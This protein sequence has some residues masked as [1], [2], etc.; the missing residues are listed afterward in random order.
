MFDTNSPTLTNFQVPT[1]TKSSSRVRDWSGCP[2]GTAASILDN[3]LGL[4]SKGLTEQC[5]FHSDVIRSGNA[6]A[7]CENTKRDEE[8]TR[9]IFFLCKINI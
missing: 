5:R 9:S 4:G 6:K 1:Q 8:R 3:G 7:S 2:I